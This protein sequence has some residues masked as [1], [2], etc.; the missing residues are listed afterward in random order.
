[1]PLSNWPP[2]AGSFPIWPPP[3]FLSDEFY[4]SD[5]K[6]LLFELQHFGFTQS[7]PT[8][9]ETNTFFRNVRCD[10]NHAVVGRM[11]V[12]PDGTRRYP[13]AACNNASHRQLLVLWG[14]DY[15]CGGG[16]GIE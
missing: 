5:L 14:P 8:S 6:T 1:M 3:E 16:S 10:E 15:C 4:T 12:S 11:L 7:A 2:P 9:E 13:F